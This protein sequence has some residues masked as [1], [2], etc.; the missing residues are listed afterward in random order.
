MGEVGETLRA[1]LGAG[2]ARSTSTAASLVTLLEERIA[3]LVERY[4]GARKR[5]EELQTA[6]DEREGRLAELN[7][8]VLAH[9]R[10]R[11][12]L[13]ERVSRLIDQ[14]A[15]LEQVRGEARPE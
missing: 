11:S 14:I 3:S 2:G 1:P 15:E 10:L 13:R 4:R 7:E 6:L 9:A 8:E 12:E 5:I